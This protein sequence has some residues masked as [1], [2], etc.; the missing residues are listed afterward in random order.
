MTERIYHVATRADWDAAKRAGAYTTST[1][2]RTLEQEGFIHASRREQVAG[3]FARYYL[4]AGEPLVLLV[5]DPSRLD[6]EVRQDA[7]GEETFPH[8]YGPITP[9]AVVD[10]VPLRPDG[11]S[12]SV[13]SLF[14]REA[15]VRMAVGVVV[16]TAAVLGAVIGGAVANG[17][18]ANGS[19]GGWG[20]A[21][22]LVLGTALGITA[23][24]AWRRLRR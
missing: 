10:V 22:G 2:G 9:G 21:A 6:A 16:M 19:A 17:L 8:V 11:S 7:V 20:N 14:V 3:A 18:V 1:V 24:A 4:D 13:L 12:D 15:V 5:I 23:V